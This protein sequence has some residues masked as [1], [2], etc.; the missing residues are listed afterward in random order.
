MAAAIKGPPADSL[1]F[2]RLGNGLALVEP[3]GLERQ[4]GMPQVNPVHGD[5]RLGK[6]P[7]CAVV[8]S[9]GP[10]NRNPALGAPH[11]DGGYLLP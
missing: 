10:A 4:P 8:G 3:Q 2:R 1:A 9:K 11:F 7:G 5:R 6:D